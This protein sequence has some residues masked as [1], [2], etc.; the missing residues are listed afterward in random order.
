MRRRKKGG[1]IPQL[2]VG[3]QLK[4]D[5]TKGVSA[6]Q[7]FTQPPVRYNYATLT[8]ALDENGIGRPSTYAPILTNIEQREYITKIGKAYAPTPLGETVTDLM[9]EYFKKIVDVKFTAGMEESLDEI[10]EGKKNWV[11]V[12]KQ[13]LQ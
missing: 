3:E 1:A 2:T 7:H 4:A 9:C 5:K 11:D 12:V 13:I 8:K 10:G 6:E